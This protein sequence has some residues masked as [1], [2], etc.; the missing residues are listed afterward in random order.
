MV[1]MEKGDWFFAAC[2]S[3]MAVALCVLVYLLFFVRRLRDA[4][5]RRAP[6]QPLTLRTEECLARSDFSLQARHA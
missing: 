4:F 2:V 3:G 1:L 6:A 5:D